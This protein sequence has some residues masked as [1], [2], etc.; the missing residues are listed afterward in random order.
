MT[1]TFE[2]GTGMEHRWGKRS[3]LDIGVRLRLG[4]GAVDTGRLV[5]A[6]LSGAFVRTSHCLPAFSRVVVELDSGAARQSA[7]QRIPAYVVRVAPDGVGLEWSEF[8]PPAIATLLVGTVAVRSRNA[9]VRSA[10]NQADHW[11]PR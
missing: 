11:T 5:N 10:E 1:A 7:P 2:M 9:G 4:S 6:S 3:A 8:A